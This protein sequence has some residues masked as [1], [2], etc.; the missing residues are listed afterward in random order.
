VL[1]EGEARGRVTGLPSLGGE[2]YQAWLVNTRTDETLSF[3]TF[4]TDEGQRGQFRFIVAEDIPERDWNLFL[5]TVEPG[6]DPEPAHQSD[7]RSIGAYFPGPEQERLFPNE[8]PNTGGPVS[9]AASGGR[10]VETAPGGAAAP[11]NP[12]ARVGTNQTQSASADFV[13]ARPAGATSVAGQGA[14]P[15]GSPN[16]GGERHPASQPL[17]PG[18]AD[19]GSP[20]GL[21]GLGGQ[22]AGLAAVL[23][24][25]AFL[26]GWIVRGRRRP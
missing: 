22:G 25:A 26:A 6:A 7:Q 24:S 11:P 15:P 17:T 21:G 4:N 16:A 9:E 3:G 20:P 1:A 12:P 8:L 13:A 5:L 14:A 10:A 2:V 19:R 23:A 18:G